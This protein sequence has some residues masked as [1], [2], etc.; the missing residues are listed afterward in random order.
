VRKLE[1]FIS[2]GT[3]G[4][5]EEKLRAEIDEKNRQLQTLVNGLATENLEMKARLARVELE[6]TELKK[7]LQKLLET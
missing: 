7:E 5:I 1:P 3:G 6:I 2:I 4:E